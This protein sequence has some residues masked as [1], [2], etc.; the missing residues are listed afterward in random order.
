MGWGGV[1]GP[2]VRDWDEPGVQGPALTAPG[3]E[4]EVLG[5]SL[6]AQE[7]SSVEA[8]SGPGSSP[9]NSGWEQRSR[10][11]AGSQ[12]HWPHSAGSLT[13]P[14]PTSLNAPRSVTPPLEPTS[15]S[16]QM[17]LQVL[18]VPGLLWTSSFSAEFSISICCCSLELPLLRH[19]APH[20]CAELRGALA[21]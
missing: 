12:K 9:K 10:S 14:P 21:L 19:V 5:A 2:V 17:V 13:T 16:T 8:G 1:P 20:L 3:C 18:R 7:V 4:F 6:G 11:S 15:P